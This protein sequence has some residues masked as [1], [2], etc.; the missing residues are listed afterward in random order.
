ML[1][2]LSLGLFAGLC[3]LVPCS[4]SADTLV[5]VKAGRVYVASADGSAGRSVSPASQWWKW[6]SETDNGR[7]AVAGGAERVNPGG[8]TESSGSS[9]IYE[10]DQQGHSLLSSPVQTPGSVSSPTNPTYVDHFRISPDGR[11]VAY[12]V[13][14]CCGLSG[15]AAFVSPLTA[16][17]SAWVDFQDDYV[18]PS[19]VN[20]S[21]DSYIDNDPHALGLTHNG[22]PAFGNAE[23]AVYH[24]SNR[25]GGNGSGWAGD[26]SIPDG[27][28]FEV[29]FARDLRHDA[30][31]TENAADNGGSASSVQI[32]LETPQ[33]SSNG[34]QRYDCTITLS[35]AQFSQAHALTQAS[36]TYS[37]DDR[38]IAW[39]QD[40]GI[41]EA[42]VSN[43]Q[44]CSAVSSSVHRVVAG[45]GMPFLSPARL[46]A[47]RPL[48]RFS[49]SPRHPHKRR[50]VHFNASA[51]HESGGRIVSYRWSFGDGRHGAGLKAS[52]AYAHA[53]R[54]RVTLT[55]RDAAG[56]SART[57]EKVL[58]A[59]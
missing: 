12:N 43:P 56:R 29:S 41:Y 36:V 45:G 52:H 16:G 59:R 25:N 8:A 33:W 35:A 19:W 27:Y 48:A 31:F 6:P 3:L 17:S 21:V 42:N 20:G 10:F 57:S 24:A 18:D 23:Y 47:A 26:A 46:T 32:H 51:S 55:V 28:G 7:I 30:I 40:D 58:V 22:P 49:Y 14:G 11:T 2:R 34:D 9:E 54:Y 53:G 37:S 13:L 15:A 44:D 50:K 39:A 1:G 5:Y 38:T 4:A